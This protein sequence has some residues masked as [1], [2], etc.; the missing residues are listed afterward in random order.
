MT[1]DRLGQMTGR[2]FRSLCRSGEFDGPTAGVALGTVQANLVVLRAAV[3]VDFTEFCKLNPKPCPLLETTAPGGY[4]PVRV[5]SGADLRTDLPR[6]RIY[7]GGICRDRPVSIIRYWEDDFVAFLIGCS[8]TF[9]S[10][11]LKAGLPV[12]HIEDGVN[13]PMYRTNIACRP[14]GRFSAPLVVS[15]RP[16]SP[17]QVDAAKRVTA[18]FPGTHGEP[19]HAGEP[20]AIG[21]C[22]LDRPDYGEAVTIR[23]GE[24]PVFWAC[25]V[26]PM[27]AIMRAK[28]DI[29]IT[30]EPGHMFVTDLPD[31]EL[32]STH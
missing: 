17:W 31:T 1:N 32:L 3:A 30:H 28:P 18:A 29:A 5:A 10:A 19:V 22:D 24:I 20:A 11:L 7:E 16:M 26:T 8:F 4:E 12:R 21:I 25:G 15:M 27:E 14:A 6:Y 13:V 23:P 2:E 9:E